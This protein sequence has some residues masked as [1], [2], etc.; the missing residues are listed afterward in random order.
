MF[1]QNLRGVFLITIFLNNET[2]DYWSFTISDSKKFQFELNIAG[3][4]LEDVVD[5]K[6]VW[7]KNL[8]PYIILKN[9]HGILSLYYWNNNHWKMK[10]LHELTEIKDYLVTTLQNECHIVASQTN[11]YLHISFSD[12]SWN[13]S[14]LPITPFSGSEILSLHRTQS[15]KMLQLILLQNNNLIAWNY[16]LEN[17]KW[18]RGKLLVCLKRVFFTKISL[19]HCNWHLIAAEKASDFVNLNYFLFKDDRIILH[20]PIVTSKTFPFERQPLLLKDKNQLGLFGTKNKR[21][22]LF[23][24]ADKG[25]KWRGIVSKETPFLL[26]FDEVKYQNGEISPYIV[27]K[28]INDKELKPALPLHLNDLIEFSQGLPGL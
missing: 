20:S 7:S 25:H 10:I 21:L 12:S 2:G 23:T 5:Y 22:I 13:I 18:S 11:K 26:H 16:S 27:L 19:S 28:R 1:T 24:S 8:I 6:V 4:S 14:V 17:G 9:S 3:N 15:Q